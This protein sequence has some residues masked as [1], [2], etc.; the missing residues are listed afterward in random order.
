MEFIRGRAPSTPTWKA[1]GVACRLSGLPR[2]PPHR[3][4]YA[5]LLVICGLARTGAFAFWAKTAPDEASGPPI[6][7]AG[8]GSRADV[9]CGR[10]HW[11]Q[12]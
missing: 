1:A 9:G 8:Q 11:V 7:C 12:G 10:P 6:A 5:G 2:L 4:Q 3:P